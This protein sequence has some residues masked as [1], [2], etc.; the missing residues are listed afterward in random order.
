MKQLR[1]FFLSAVFCCLSAHAQI[2]E[3]RNEL[4]AGVNGGV[5]LSTVSFANAEVP[6]NQLIG[7]TVGLTLRYTGE[8]YFKSICAIVAE[9]NFAQMGW[10]ERIWDIND[11][12]VINSETG[13]A[14][15]Y[16]RIVNYVQVPFFARLGWGRERRGVQAYF[17]IGPQIGYYLSEKTEAN[18]D[19]DH[20]NS[21]DRVSKTSGPDYA[22]YKYSNMYHMPIENKLDYGIAAG[23]GVELSLPHLGHVMLE[24]RYYFG[25]GNIYGNTKRDYFSK[26]N[27]QGIYVK[28]AYLFDV[29]KSKNPKIK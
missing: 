17:Q 15:E 21:Y 28:A 12:P 5:V 7:K 9:V 25:L 14:E 24:G 19:L 6:Q 13:V 29:M 11:S 20:P 16:R 2:G 10:E 22:G 8:K 27:Y 1:L 18:F 3:Y 4:A 23:L 26:S